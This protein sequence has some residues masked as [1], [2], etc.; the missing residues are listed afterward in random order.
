ML[1]ARAPIAENCS[2]DPCK[3][4]RPVVLLTE[5]RDEVFARLAYD[6]AETGV[7]VLRAKMAH[8]AV[9]LCGRYR[10]MLVLAN[11]R[12]L[13]Q[14]G[15]LMAAKMQLV[16]P[17]IRVW[18]YQTRTSSYDQRM[19][20]FLQIERLLAYGG[21]LLRLS[22]MVVALMTATPSSRRAINA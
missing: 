19:A 13:D 2:V 4:R 11:A 14:S 21:D 6:L 5:N 17:R 7:P 18:L 1:S 22:D 3:P 9:K 20:D 15:W 10:P 16:D 8:E 12:P